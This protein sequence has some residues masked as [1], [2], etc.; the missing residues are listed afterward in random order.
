MTTYRM[1]GGQAAITYR[2]LSTTSVGQNSLFRVYILAMTAALV[3][4]TA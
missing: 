3:T 4:L 1:G 2:P